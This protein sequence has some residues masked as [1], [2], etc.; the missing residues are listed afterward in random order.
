[1]FR[2]DLDLRR[3]RMFV[4]VAEA[5]SLRVAAEQMFMTQQAASAAIKELEK[6]L[7]VDLFS[8]SRRSLVLTPAGESLYAGAMALLAGGDQLISKA[9]L[10]AQG[11][12]TPFVIGH[13]PDLASSEVFTI[14]EPTVLANAGPITVRPVFEDLIHT[15]LMDGRIDLALRRGLRPSAD[16]AGTI[17]ANHALRLA[18]SA[19]HPLAEEDRVELGALADYQIAISGAD[20]ASEFTQILISICQAAGFEPNLIGS[21]LRGTPP[22]TAV[23]AQ[24]QACAFVT[25]APGWVYDHRVR[26]VEFVD[27]PTAPVLATWLPHTASAMRARILTSGA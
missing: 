7:D 17:I 21:T 4:M 16:L 14:I 20:K 2:K 5:P 12:P 19:D 6:Q 10:A 15:E 1:M 9:R 22:H 23:I 18:V 13:T 25:N 8:R 3:L 27:P 11:Q 26:I 24:P